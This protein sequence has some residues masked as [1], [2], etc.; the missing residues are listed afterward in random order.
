MT[1]EISGYEDADSYWNKQIAHFE[2]PGEVVTACGRALKA[3]KQAVEQI[4]LA[5]W[6]TKKN[7]SGPYYEAVSQRL[8]QHLLRYLQERLRPQMEWVRVEFDHSCQHFAVARSIDA[9]K[10]SALRYLADCGFTVTV[11]DENES[12]LAAQTKI[13]QEVEGGWGAL[14]D[15][16]APRDH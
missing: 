12:K 5:P 4:Y 10:T 8:Q 1:D 15:I 3:A 11:L 9:D 16:L 7:G 6:V 13:Y 2:T 14:S